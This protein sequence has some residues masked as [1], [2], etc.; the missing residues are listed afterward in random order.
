MTLTRRSC[1]SLSLATLAGAASSCKVVSEPSAPAVA[2]GTV[3][4]GA[5]VT[6]PD[7]QSFNLGNSVYLNA[8]SQFPCSHAARASVEAYLAHKQSFETTSGYRLD[9]EGPIQKFARLVNA[10]PEEITYV[11]STTAGEQAIIR[12]LGLP[13]T[14]AKVVTDTLHFFG[15]LPL[16]VDLGKLGCDVA[17]VKARSD[18]RIHLEDL[19]EAITPGTRLVSLSLVSTINGFEH[20]LK[21]VCDLAHSRGALVYADIIHAAG[22][23]PVDLHASGVDFAA[24]ASYKWLMGDFGLG[25][26]YMRKGA[27]AHLKRRNWGYYGISEFTSHVY[28]LDPPGESAADYAFQD[29]A[30]GWFAIGT[31]SHT[32]VAHLNAS[33]DYI[34][35]AGAASIQ[36]YTLPLAQRLADG[37]RSQGFDV[38]TPDDCRTPIVAA[39]C[40]DAYQRFSGPMKDAG[41]ITTVSRNRIRPSVSVFN[42][43]DDVDAFLSALG[44][45]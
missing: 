27:E 7:R 8:A 25:F 40:P 2:A 42:T 34:L 12:S 19:D 10:D 9:D 13:E 43:P 4:M 1:L 38:I 3:L 29:G 30:A 35:K 44:T 6:F 21:A 11:Q 36:A 18:G 24:C 31:Y 28:P 5:A 26:L 33:L 45:A 37:M 39:A 14:G 20:D 15:S 32:T 22:C 23:I 17:W 16:Y 41:I